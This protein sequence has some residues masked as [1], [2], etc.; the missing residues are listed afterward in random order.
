MTWRDHMTPAEAR[1][2]AKIEAQRVA[3]NVEFRKIYDRCRKRADKD[4]TGK[5]FPDAGKSQT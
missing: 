1:T 2:V 3:G 5:T 4:G